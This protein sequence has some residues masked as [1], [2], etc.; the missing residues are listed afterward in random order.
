MVKIKRI[1]SSPGGRRTILLDSGEKLSWPARVITEAGVNEAD[2]YV[3]GE[4]LDLLRTTAV[5]L[6]PRVAREYLGRYEQ[7]VRRFLEHFTR[8]GYPA[9][10]VRSELDSL[11]QEGYLDDHRYAREFV[12]YRLRSSCRG[13]KLLQAE[14]QKR[15]IEADLARAVVEQ[16]LDLSTEL[17]LARRYL[18]KNSHLTRNK[19]ARRL[20]GRGFST[21]VVRDILEEQGD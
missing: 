21:A 1:F 11:Q 9:D 12:E 13:K 2:K 18:E 7:S 4:L 16:R 10:L 14:L 20:S 5:E 17:R 3:S 19:L 8:K 15:G 6:F